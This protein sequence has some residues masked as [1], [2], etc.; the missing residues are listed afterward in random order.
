MLHTGIWKIPMKS[1]TYPWSL[2]LSPVQFTRVMV[3]SLVSAPATH[4]VYQSDGCILSLRLLPV[5]FTGVFAHNVV[6]VQYDAAGFVSHV[7]LSGSHTGLSWDSLCLAMLFVIHLFWR[8]LR[9]IKQSMRWIQNCQLL[10]FAKVF[11]GPSFCNDLYR[12][13]ISYMCFMKKLSF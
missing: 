12:A 13:L 10:S 1:Y 9:L 8:A 11:C 7:V 5:Q 3:L 4:A 2:R 6:M